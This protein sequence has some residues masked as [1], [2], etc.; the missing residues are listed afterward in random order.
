MIDKRP[1]ALITGITGQDGSY[2][3]QLLLE[4]NYHIIGAVRD[5]G[6]AI[7]KLPPEITSAIELTEWNILYQNSITEMLTSHR[8]HEIYN[9]AAYSSGSGMFDDAVG[10]AEVNGVAVARILEAIRLVDDK[11]RFCQASSRE[12]F[13]EATQSPQNELTTTNP[14]SPYGAAKLYADAMIKIYR[15][16]YKIFACSAILYNHESPRRGLDFVTRKISHEAAKI[17]LGLSKELKLGNL[18]S[19]RDWGF[20]GDYVYAMWLMLQQQNPSDYVLATGEL[21]SV[22]EFCDLAFKALGLDYREYVLEDK[23]YFRPTESTPLVGDISKARSELKWQP[24]INFKSLIEMMVA[25]DLKTLSSIK[26]QG[27]KSNV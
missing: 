21:H 2:L 7:S 26:S 16:R 19:F 4:K 14:R 22:R 9:F 6:E 10:I 27:M 5:R 15:D 13:G 11:I 25:E 8:P 12:I 3:T 18:D 23:S 24:Q 20:A 17:K 1:K